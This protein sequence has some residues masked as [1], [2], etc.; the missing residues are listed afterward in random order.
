MNRI[1][2]FFAVGLMG[3]FW[4]LA[5]ANIEMSWKIGATTGN[6]GA[7]TATLLQG[8]PITVG[9]ITITGLSGFS[10]S[11][12]S[13]TAEQFSS[14]LNVSSTGATPTTTV[15]IWVASDGFSSPVTPP[16]ILF[17]SS[18]TSDSTLGAENSNL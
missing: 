10:N 5:Q 9:G 4:P 1:T 17:A 13:V 18:L 3:I 16:D 6:C 15:E 7:G 12:G 8:A 2:S 14:T 11:P